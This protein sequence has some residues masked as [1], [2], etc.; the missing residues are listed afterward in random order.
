MNFLEGTV[1]SNS[2]PDFALTDGSVIE[3]DA[4]PATAAGRVVLGVRPEDIYVD[5]EGGAPA[6]VIVVEPTGAETHLAVEFGG[7][8]LTCV[9]RERVRLQ[10]NQTVRLSFR[11]SA[12]LFFDP[13]STSRIQ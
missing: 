7:H 4:V 12:V 13:V 6:K 5:E 10:P 2:H 9:L 8:E 1:R 3:L 11:K